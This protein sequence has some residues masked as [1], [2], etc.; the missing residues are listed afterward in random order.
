MKKYAVPVDEYSARIRTI[1][2]D[3]PL[4]AH[5]YAKAGI[6]KRGASIALWSYAT[7]AAEINNGW[8]SV[9]CLSSNTTRHHVSAFLRE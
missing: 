2:C 8:L 4:K 3:M 1:I 7:C 5:P 9:H 6:D